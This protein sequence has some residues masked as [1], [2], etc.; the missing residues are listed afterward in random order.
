MTFYLCCDV[1][2]KWSEFIYYQ[3]VN[4]VKRK[5]ANASV[6]E[7]HIGWY[8]VG[9]KKMHKEIA[10]DPKENIVAD[11]N[12]RIEQ[13]IEKHAEEA[14]TLQFY[15]KEKRMHYDGNDEN[16]TSCDKQRHAIKSC[17]KPSACNHSKTNA[18]NGHQRNDSAEENT[19]FDKFAEYYIEPCYHEEKQAGKS[20]S[21]DIGEK[22]WEIWF[23]MSDK[24]SV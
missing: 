5:S 20:R 21:N 1:P 12:C 19:V 17:F 7:Y 2:Q 4:S 10:A 3:R 13:E 8:S 16:R 11:A 9:L 23:N 18:D 6:Y 24:E 14:H 15:H 22:G